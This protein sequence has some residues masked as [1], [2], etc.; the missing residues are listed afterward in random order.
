MIQCPKCQG[1]NISHIIGEN[2]GM[3]MCPDCG[4]SRAHGVSGLYFEAL[5]DWCEYQ[6]VDVPDMKPTNM[7]E[8][9]KCQKEILSR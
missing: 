4:Y 5:C 9:E 8:L 7:E 1:E 2:I 3:A 6:G